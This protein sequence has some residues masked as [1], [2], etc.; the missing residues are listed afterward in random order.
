MLPIDQSMENN[1]PSPS[2]RNL[3]YTHLG[4]QKNILLI[5][6]HIAIENTASSLIYL[7]KM[8]DFPGRKLWVYK[9]WTS[10]NSGALESEN[11]KP[12]QAWPNSHVRTMVL[13]YWP[14]ALGDFLWANSG[15][16]FHIHGA[17]CG[18]V[19]CWTTKL[20]ATLGQRV[21]FRSLAKSSS[22]GRCFFL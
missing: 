17:S 11:F 14:T 6:F 16:I 18:F 8:V 2:C 9:R 4:D 21:L 22:L 1:N 13:V 3:W 20:S 5:I 19:F 15:E 12:W 7:F 10:G